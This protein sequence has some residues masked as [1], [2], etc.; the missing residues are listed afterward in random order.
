M[1]E[2]STTAHLRRLITLTLVAVALTLIVWWC[3]SISAIK[4]IALWLGLE[5]TALLASALTPPVDQMGSDV[6]RG[7]KQIPWW[8]S[9]G[10]T[11]GWPIHYNP[12][13]YYGG[14]V[15]LAASI[16]LS[17]IMQ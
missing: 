4:V 1:E 8:F 12:V 15:F 10:S 7:L 16:V 2:Q 3:W 5:G 17:A 9:E 6:P 11:L 14:L 13:C